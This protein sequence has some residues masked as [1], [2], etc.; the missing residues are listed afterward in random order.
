M[1]RRVEIGAQ[2]VLDF[3]IG[4][5]SVP[6]PACSHLYRGRRATSQQVHCHTPA[7]VPQARECN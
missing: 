7:I 2:N 5:P 3:S 4:N 1:Q 6:A